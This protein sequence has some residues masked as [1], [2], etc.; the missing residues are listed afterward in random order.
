[1]DREKIQCLPSENDIREMVDW[2]NIPTLKDLKD[3]LTE[4]TPSHNNHVSTVNEY[5]ST[6]RGELRAKIMEGRSKVQPKLVRKQGEWRY[7]ALEEPFLSTNDMFKVSPVTY[8]DV[9][10]ARQN[11]LILNKQFRVDIPKVKLI[12]RLVRTAV[13]TGTVI[14]K[15][16][17]ETEKDTV[18][19]EV[20]VFTKSLE[21]TYEVLTQMVQAGQ[22]SEEE[23]I[24]ILESG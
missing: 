21:E 2:K 5:I 15:L 16:G 13:N 22:I 6:L 1:M 8:A 17:W 10:S 19:E 12:N 3:N 24:Q 7:S 9:E 4:A 14:I 18:I 20:P 23:S 11:E